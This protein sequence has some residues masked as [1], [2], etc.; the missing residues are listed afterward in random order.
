[1]ARWIVTMI[2]AFALPFSALADQNCDGRGKKRICLM[3]EK[4][5]LAFL[6]PFVLGLEKGELEGAFTVYALPHHPHFLRACP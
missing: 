2:L 5:D 6:K 1:M 3:P 4:S